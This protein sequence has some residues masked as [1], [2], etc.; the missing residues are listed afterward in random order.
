MLALSLFFYTHI[1]LF[2]TDQCDKVRVFWIVMM[3]I[4]DELR[5][6]CEFGVDSIVQVTNMVAIIRTYIVMWTF[7]KLVRIFYESNTW[8]FLNS[9]S[10]FSAVH[11]LL[12]P[13]HIHI[14]MFTCSIYLLPIWWACGCPKKFFYGTTKSISKAIIWWN[15]R[16]IK[17]SFCVYRQVIIK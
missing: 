5:Y 17:I 9:K 15:Y 16:I 4:M 8:F 6:L 7:F 11:F 13:C 14:F 1:N 2:A 10:S 3:D 12:R